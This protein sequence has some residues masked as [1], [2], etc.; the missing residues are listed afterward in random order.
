MFVHS[1]N[2]TMATAYLVTM[3]VMDIVHARMEATN[4]AVVSVLGNR[5]SPVRSRPT[6]ITK[7]T[8]GKR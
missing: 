2:A 1:F 3:S 4:E 8:H 7:L 5:M 6:D